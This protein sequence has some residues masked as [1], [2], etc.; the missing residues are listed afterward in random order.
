MF[1]LALLVLAGVCQLVL[2]L[3]GLRLSTRRTNRAQKKQYEWTFITVGLI[4]LG[5]IALSG[6]RSVSVQ[7]VI[8]DGIEKIETKL[9]I[10]K[11]DENTAKNAAT[12]A[13]LQDFYIASDSLL[14]R[15]IGMDPS[16]SDDDFSKYQKEL[17][18]WS[19]NLEKYIIANVGPAANARML[20]LPNPLIQFNPD[21]KYGKFAA[22]RARTLFALVTTRQNLEKLIDSL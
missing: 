21:P 16:I 9:R 2:G 22:D 1:D 10:V 12:K 14:R 17:D 18:D 11:P 19:L 8:A 13:K 20:D 3:L 15:L 7:M 6:Y 5:A 4:G